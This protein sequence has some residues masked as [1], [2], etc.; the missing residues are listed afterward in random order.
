L[1]EVQRLS[2]KASLKR[3]AISGALPNRIIRKDL[4]QKGRRTVDDDLQWHFNHHFSF[5]FISGFMK[6]PLRCDGFYGVWRYLVRFVLGGPMGRTF[7]T[8]FSQV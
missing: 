8:F 7:P 2:S 6:W 5:S 4:E 1:G 3:M